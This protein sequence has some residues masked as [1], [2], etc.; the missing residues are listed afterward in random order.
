[1]TDDVNYVWS[2]S[3][4]TEFVYGEFDVVQDDRQSLSEFD[5]IGGSNKIITYPN[6]SVIRMDQFVIHRCG[7]IT[8]SKIRQ[9]AK[10]SISKDIYDLVGNSHNYLFEYDWEM[11]P[12]GKDRNIPQKLQ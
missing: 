6:N 8:E 7:E 10:I 4:P 11:R 9:F 3:F 12:R 5:K 2:D 1:M